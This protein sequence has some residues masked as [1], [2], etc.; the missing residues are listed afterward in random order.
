MAY[1]ATIIL[2]GLLGCSPLNSPLYVRSIDKELLPYVENWERETGQTVTFSVI[3]NNDMPGL[4]GRCRYFPVYDQYDQNK[5]F[6]DKIEI[7]LKNLLRY[8]VNA[9]YALEQVIN[10]ELHH[11]LKGRDHNNLLLTDGCPSSIM[12]SNTF[13]GNYCYIKHRAYYWEEVRRE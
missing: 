5:R 11:C 2:F 12:Y 3:I 4:D 1:L 13:G 10:H 8:G 9:N 6:P 7:N